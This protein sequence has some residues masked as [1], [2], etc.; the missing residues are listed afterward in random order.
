MKQVL[1]SSHWAWLKGV[2]ANLDTMQVIESWSW[3]WA[4]QANQL[5]WI[6]SWALN[7]HNE[8]D[9]VRSYVLARVNQVLHCIYK[10]VIFTVGIH[11]FIPFH[12]FHSVAHCLV[13]NT[14]PDQLTSLQG[15][16]RTSRLPQ[17]PAAWTSQA[18]S[19]GLT[20]AA[21]SLVLHSPPAHTN[22]G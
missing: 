19:P 17:D 3:S 5:E 13:S 8:V 20:P 10:D 1:G 16:P 12:S 14:S 4:P 7:N 2:L 9:P 11:S 15:S 18:H 21:A 6:R 22:L